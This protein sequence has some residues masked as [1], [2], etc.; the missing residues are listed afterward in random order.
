MRCRNI[1]TQ[2]SKGFAIDPDNRIN[3]FLI[4]EIIHMVKAEVQNLSACAYD[5]LGKFFIF[6]KISRTHSGGNFFLVQGFFI[7]AADSVPL[8]ESRI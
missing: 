1:F 2:I 4:L 6:L 5:R 3:K 8:G 7:L